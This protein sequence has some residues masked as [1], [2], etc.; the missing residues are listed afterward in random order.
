MGLTNEH[1]VPIK[2]PGTIATNDGF[3]WRKYTRMKEE[4]TWP[5]TDLAHSAW[6]EPTYA[7]DKG[8]EHKE[9]ADF[10]TINK[11][12]IPAMPCVKQS[13]SSTTPHREKIIEKEPAYNAMV[14]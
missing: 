5:M 2:K 3:L 1:G 12:V 13:P 14:S 9:A 6:R 8:L 11:G 4:Y 7:L 10:R